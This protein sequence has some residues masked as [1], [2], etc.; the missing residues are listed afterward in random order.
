[1]DLYLPLR[2]TFHDQ[3]NFCKMKK[4]WMPLSACCQERIFFSTLI[5]MMM[6]YFFN[7]K[8]LYVYCGCDIKVSRHRSFFLLGTTSASWFD[9]VMI[10]HEKSL[11]VTMF[12]FKSLVKGPTPYQKLLCSYKSNIQNLDFKNQAPTSMVYYLKAVSVTPKNH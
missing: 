5:C 2:C 1:M 8:I 9:N 7:T 3:F 6:S 12:F 4:A 10:N 11:K